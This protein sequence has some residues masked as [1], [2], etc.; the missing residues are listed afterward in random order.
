[1]EDENKKEMPEGVKNI[2][3]KWWF[4]ICIVSIVLVVIIVSI[5]MIKSSKLNSIDEIS[6]EINEELKCA[7]LFVSKES[8]T[9]ILEL[10]DFDSSKQS[11]KY[12]NVIKII[13]DNLDGELKDFS[14]LEVISHLAK[15]NSESNNGLIVITT[16]ELPSFKEISNNN[17]IDFEAYKDLYDTYDE[18]MNSYTNLFM[19]IGR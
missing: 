5:I 15:N 8:E 9:L 18:T 12:S 19:S 17:Y 1:M 10:K 13:K 3:K 4:W 11:S 6:K 16:F 2:F 14:T 7:N